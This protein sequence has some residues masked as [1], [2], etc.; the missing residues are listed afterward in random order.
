MGTYFREAMMVMD[1]LPQLNKIFCIKLDLGI[2]IF[3]LVLIVLSFLPYWPPSFILVLIPGFTDSRH[4]WVVI[5]PLLVNVI[6]FALV[7]LALQCFQ[8]KIAKVLL[9]PAAVLAPIWSVV[10]LICLVPSFVSG[11]V[12]GIA[13]VIVFLLYFCLESFLHAYYWLGLISLYRHKNI[14]SDSSLLVNET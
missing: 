4:Y 14:S 7:P 2:K 9:V 13:L 3:S 1:S 5:L 12:S 11:T 6:T 8:W 10:C